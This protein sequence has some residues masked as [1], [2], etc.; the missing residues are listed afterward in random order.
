MKH[1][2]RF[3]E[4][5]DVWMGGGGA[6]FAFVTFVNED[7]ARSLVG[8]CHNVE[9]VLIDIN[10]AKPDWRREERSIRL[11]LWNK[12]CTFFKEGRCLRHGHCNFQH[13]LESRRSRSRSRGSVRRR[14]KSSS[15]E[16]DKEMSR[17]KRDRV[18]GSRFG[19]GKREGGKNHDSSTALLG[20]CNSERGGTLRSPPSVKEKI[21]VGEE[22]PKSADVKE[23][24]VSKQHTK[25]VDNIEGRSREKMRQTRRNESKTDSSGEKMDEEAMKRRIKELEQALEA[26]EEA[27]DRKRLLG[28]RWKQMGNLLGKESRRSKKNC[29]LVKSFAKRFEG[30]GN[31]STS[32]PS[33]ANDGYDSTSDSDIDSPSPSP[34]SRKQVAPPKG[35]VDASWQVGKLAEHMKRRRTILQS[36]NSNDAKKI[37]EQNADYVEG[38]EKVTD[39]KGKAG[40]VIADDNGEEIPSSSTGWLGD[41]EADGGEKPSTAKEDIEDS[42]WGKEYVEEQQQVSDVDDQECHHQE[43]KEYNGGQEDDLD[44]NE[45]MLGSEMDAG[46][47]G[48]V[49]SVAT[50]VKLISFYRNYPN[51]FDG[52]MLFY[53]SRAALYRIQI[54][55]LSTRWLQKAHASSTDWAKWS[56]SWML[57]RSLLA[58]K[59]SNL[60]IFVG[61]TG[62]R[63]YLGFL[64]ALASLKPHYSSKFT[65]FFR[66]LRY[67]SNLFQIY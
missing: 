43:P 42:D 35:L 63:P 37:E 30:V 2:R 24:K 9:G 34:P 65:H 54:H 18:R 20:D 26:K 5:E 38:E 23:E 19:N 16:R 51:R 64:D 8:A 48:E 13:T 45:N 41:L 12:T 49:A 61:H 57:F 50:C 22:S 39:Q 59:L 21:K 11:P 28:N 56:Q 33:E 10:K 53:K 15:A 32:S 17:T 4:L 46:F 29:Y 52:T 62:Y 40:S 36:N 67:I 58:T 55:S 44:T 31:E 14:E 27:D 6:F 66:L 3:G 60:S 1:F 7:V 25:E 47:G